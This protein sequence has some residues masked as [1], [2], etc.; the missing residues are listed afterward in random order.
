FAGPKKPELLAQ[1]GP[2]DATLESLIDYGWFDWVAVPLLWILHGFYSIVHNYGIAII[3][4]TVVV[5]GCLFP[6]SRKQVL[7]AQIMQQKMSEMQPE[8]RKINEKYKGNAE[9]RARA[10]QE[11]WRKHDY[12]PAAMLGGC[13]LMFLQLPIFIGLYR[14]LMVDVELRQAPLIS[15][16]VRW[17]SNLGAPDMLY[18]WGHWPLPGFLIGETGWLGPYFNILPI[19]TVALFLWQQK[20][21]MPPPADEQAAMQQKVMQYMMIVIAFMF[22]K[23][24]SGLCIYFIASSL[25]GIA[26][27]KVLPKPTPKPAGNEPAAVPVKVGAS[28]N[29][30]GTATA[31]KKKQK[32]K[33]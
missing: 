8:M 12:H 20:M 31:R 13:L 9:Q 23:V 17:C 27:R 30:S 4:L 26:E 21:F 32:G 28:S 3:L 24:A 6:L 16:A 22:F 33:R 11:L 7:S 25:W 1:Y 18:Y 2:Q 10:M 29:G 19:I 14:S 15:E 5:R